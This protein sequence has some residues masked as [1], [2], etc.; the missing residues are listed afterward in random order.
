VAGALAGRRA[1]LGRSV[2]VASSAPKKATRT[3]RPREAG[4]LGSSHFVR[5]G[6]VDRKR[7]VVMGHNDKSGRPLADP[8][9]PARLKKLLQIDD[10][11]S[12]G[13]LGARDRKVLAEA[14]EAAAAR[15]GL[16]VHGTRNIPLLSSIVEGMA[17]NRSDD[18]PF[19]AAGVPAL[20]FG[21]GESD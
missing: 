19:A 2:L 14:V 8:R 21:S 17:R 5:S 18:A 16:Q 15:A 20:F 9:A 3:E 12:L 4:V 10:R 6:V 13:V 1:S 7:L 11:N